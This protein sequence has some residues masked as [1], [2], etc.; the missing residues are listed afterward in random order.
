[1]PVLRTLTQVPTARGSVVLFGTMAQSPTFRASPRGGAEDYVQ[2]IVHDTVQP[3]RQSIASSS[4]ALNGGKGQ[5]GYARR[6]GRLLV[7]HGV[8]PLVQVPELRHARSIRGV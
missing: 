2:F 8:S 5:R 4:P 3:D 6:G 1:M 7:G